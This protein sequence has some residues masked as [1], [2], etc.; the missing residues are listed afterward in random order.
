[1]LY[2][3][4]HVAGLIAGGRFQDPL[5]D[6]VDVVTFSTYK[7]FGGPPGGVI[8]TNDAEVAE[9]VFAAVHPGLTANYDAGRFR[10][11]GIAA[12]Q[13]LDSG[14]AYAAR[15]IESAQALGRAL[16]DAGLSVVGA[17][18]GFT[19]SHQVAIALPEAITGEWAVGRLARAGVYLSATHDRERGRSRRRPATRH[20][21][22]GRARLRP[23]RHARGRRR[24]RP[25]TRRHGGALRC[26]PGRRGTPPPGGRSAAPRARCAMTSSIIASARHGRLRGV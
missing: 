14:A 10:A 8:A 23:A 12:A 25:G 22:A 15:C 26:A 9:R 5:G 7:S 1:M 16:S 4:S 18:R 2:D 17:D 21:G 20:A 3:A 24:D 6:G 11:I 13:L 19:A